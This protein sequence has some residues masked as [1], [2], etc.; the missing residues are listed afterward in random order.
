MKISI[1]TINYN[2]KE[3]LAK[4]IKSV[5]NQSTNDFEYIVVDGGS[6]DGSLDVIKKNALSIHYWVS[7]KDTGIYNAM[8]KGTKAAHG[9]YC[10]FLNSGDILIDSDIIKNV[11]AFNFSA[12]IISGDEKYTSGRKTK[13]PKRV[14]M[15]TFIIGSLPHQATFIKRELLLD[16]PYDER[17]KIGGDWRFFIQVL[18][19]KNVSYEKIPM[20]ISLFDTTGISST[21]S[22]QSE[23]R[24]FE[25][26][27]CRDILPSRIE[28]DYKFDLFIAKW[29]WRFTKLC[30]ILIGVLHFRR[31][32]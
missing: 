9:D 5:I 2:N 6:S 14:S 7:E 28:D 1:I 16:N 25:K 12:D 13:A 17:F 11:L 3:G 23:R 26:E 18:I 31:Y 27:L 8:N 22:K 30:T 32:G 10:L 24:L 29:K 21:E 15:K 20:V 4:T 19:Y